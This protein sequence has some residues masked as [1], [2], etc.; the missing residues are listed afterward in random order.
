MNTLRIETQLTPNH[1]YRITISLLLQEAITTT[2]L[3]NAI[4]VTDLRKRSRFVVAMLWIWIWIEIMDCLDG[5]LP[6]RKLTLTAY[7]MNKRAGVRALMLAYTMGQICTGTA[8]HCDC[9]SLT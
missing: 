8:G 5:H 9:M 7:T 4:F 6:G 2:L 3:E 1:H